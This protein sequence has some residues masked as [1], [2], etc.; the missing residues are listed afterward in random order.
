MALIDY[1]IARDDAEA[2]SVTP[3][4]GG[5]RS[6]G[7]TTLYAQVVDPF[8]GL[9]ALESILTGR[10]IA[11]VGGDARHCHVVA[12]HGSEPGRTDSLV[13]TVTDTLRDALAG[14]DHEHLRTTASAWAATK[15]PND[16]AESVTLDEFVRHFAD[17]ARGAADTG[18]RLYCW[19]AG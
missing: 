11:E 10:A 13:V 3:N 1:F 9:M 7:F 14:A 4:A 18:G 6:D 19:W 12:G 15:P 17:L 16:R 2:A 8:E 5:P